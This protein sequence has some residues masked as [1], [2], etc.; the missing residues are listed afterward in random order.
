MAGV[1]IY[2]GVGLRGYVLGRQAAGVANVMDPAL[3]GAPR[4]EE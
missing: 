4:V 2:R 1:P 3:L